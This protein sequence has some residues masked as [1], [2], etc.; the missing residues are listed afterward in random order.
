M[1]PLDGQL[2]F[3]LGLQVF[4]RSPLPYTVLWQIAKRSTGLDATAERHL[5]DADKNAGRVITLLED[6]NLIARRD[7]RWVATRAGREIV[8]QLEKATDSPPASVIEGRRLLAVAADDEGGL[9]TAERI[10]HRADADV[11]YA[12]G[13]Y[14]LLAILPDDHALANDLRKRLRRCGHQVVA[15]RIIGGKP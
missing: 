9:D 4:V 3:L 14:E 6:E 1:T 10:L 8:R 13:K 11:L 2:Q 7:D 12:E 15:A 5:R